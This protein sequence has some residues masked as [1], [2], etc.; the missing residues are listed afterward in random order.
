MRAWGVVYHAPSHPKVGFI[1]V[2]I[3]RK[4]ASALARRQVWRC[5]TWKAFA[6]PLGFRQAR[7]S[8]TMSGADKADQEADQG[9]SGGEAPHVEVERKLF[10]STSQLEGLRASYS[11]L[12]EKVIEDV[13]YDTASWKLTTRD[14]WLR[15]RGSAWELKVAVQKGEG[16]G[17][18]QA[19]EEVE[20]QQAVLRWLEADGLL[21]ESSAGDISIK[22]Q[23]H[24]SEDSRTAC[25]SALEAL[26]SSAG[27]IP[28]AKLRTKRCSLQ[29]SA[30]VELE[31]GVKDVLPLQID[32]DSVYFDP[33]L[34]TAGLSASATEAASEPFCIAEFELIVP[35]RPGAIVAAKEAL[36]RFLEKHT[37]CDAPA[38][39]SKLLEYMLRFRPSQVD[40]LDSAGV[41]SKAKLERLRDSRAPQPSQ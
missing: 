30:E 23:K 35:K 25:R 32:I 21:G 28:F 24:S 15:S 17:V 22:R 27:V 9:Q 41:I 4:P 16:L 5:W 2:A 1:S 12:K 7:R 34:A 38:A 11:V 3:P 13:Y 31:T 19:Y 36:D 40:A 20:G 10:L 29:A 39:Y 8:V 18:S 33:L 14:L 37:L 26:L 6:A